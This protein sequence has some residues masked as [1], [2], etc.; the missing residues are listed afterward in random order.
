MRDFLVGIFSCLII[1]LAPAANGQDL[2]KTSLNNMP[3]SRIQVT[4][5]AVSPSWQLVWDEAREMVKKNELDGA[6]ALYRELLSD[7][8]GLIEARW[9]LALALMR[10]NKE[11]QAILELEHVVEARPHDIQALFI[12]AELLSRSGLCDKAAV[13]YKNLV[14]EL[15]LQGE[16]VQVAR[17]EL[18]SIPEELTLVKVL[19]GLDR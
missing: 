2:V 11:S 6:V 5:E 16:N 8:Q 17:N 4:H 14:T 9:E 19:E 15:S 1:I 10:L 12:L 13:I 3:Q 18:L 7:R